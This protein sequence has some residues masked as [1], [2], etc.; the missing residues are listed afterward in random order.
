M[1]DWGANFHD[2]LD[3]YQ[4]LSMDSIVL[5]IEFLLQQLAWTNCTP[6]DFIITNTKS[7][8]YL[9]ESFRVAK[10]HIRPMALTYIDPKNKQSLPAPNS[11]PYFDAFL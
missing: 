11:N 6:H 7:H 1:Y 3:F 9:L 10:S 5:L 8:T 4:M 2:C